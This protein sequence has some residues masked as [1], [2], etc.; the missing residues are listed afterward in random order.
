M[1]PL[2]QLIV[3]V[4]T[5]L[6]SVLD[7][8]PPPLPAQFGRDDPAALPADEKKETAALMRVNHVGEVCAQALYRA[9][10]LT[11]RNP[12]L[13]QKFDQAAAEEQSHLDWTRARIEQLGD[14]TSLLNPFWYAGA[15]GIGLV[16]GRL[17]D[18]IS[19]GF[20]AET[21]RQVEEHLERHL[22]RIPAQDAVSRNIVQQ[23]KQDEARHASQAI[24]QGATELPTPAKQ[25]M[26]VAAKV[27]TTVAHRI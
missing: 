3:N 6:K 23:M 12:E 19:L 8:T 5:F 1:S 11:T 2:D 18:G 13:K 10:A 14:R 17:G 16:A 9:H 26:R 24:A 7:H 4:D 27:M 21:E 20:M 22:Q 25:L 15:F